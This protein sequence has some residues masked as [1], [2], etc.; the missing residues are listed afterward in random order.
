MVHRFF[1]VRVYSVYTILREH[2]QEVL[3]S[4]GKCTRYGPDVHYIKR[5]ARGE[6]PLRTQFRTSTLTNYS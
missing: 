5:N 1:E 6:C 2:L 4:V 3:V